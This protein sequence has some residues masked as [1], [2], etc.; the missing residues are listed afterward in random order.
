[1][2]LACE[3]YRVLIRI[4]PADFRRAYGPQMLGIFS[5]TADEKR[6]GGLGALWLFL[7][8]AY[9]DIARTALTER[10]SMI[11]SDLQYALRLASH[12]RASSL[13]MVAT[14]AIAIGVNAAIFSA[15]HAVLL[16]PLPYPNP[17]RLVFIFDRPVNAPNAH[18]SETSLQNEEDWRRL[19]R[20]FTTIGSAAGF[21][22]TRTDITV[23]EALGGYAVTPGVFEALGA[24]PALGR[25]FKQSDMRPGAARSVVISNAYWRSAFGAS[26]D[27]IGKTM[28]LNDE[29]YRI[30]GVLPASF[31]MP[32]RSGFAGFQPDVF[33]SLHLDESTRGAHYLIT[34]ARLKPGVSIAAAQAD[35]D[36]VAALLRARFPAANVQLAE[37]VVPFEDEIFGSPRLMLGVA[38]AAVL[39]ILLVAC[40]NVGNMLL[41]RVAVREPEIA[42]R[43]ALGASR[44]RVITQLFIESALFSVAAVALGLIF[45]AFILNSLTALYLTDLPRIGAIH[46]SVAVL[47]FTAGLI[48]LTTII[49]GVVP[50]LT[51]SHRK[52]GGAMKDTGRGVSESRRKWLHNGA[53]VVELAVALAIV[54]SFGM[55]LRSFVAI[56][57]IEVGFSYDGVVA[58]T[59]VRPPVHRYPDAASRHAFANALL[60]RLQAIP[61]LKNAGLIVSAPLSEGNYVAEEFRIAGVRKDPNAAQSAEY[62]SMTPSALR[63]FGFKLLHGRLFDERD[64][65]QAR[66]VA[67]ITKTFVKQFFPHSNPLGRTIIVG[68]EGSSEPRTIVGVIED[69]KAE[70][71]TETPLPQIVVPIAQ[72]IVPNFQIVGRSSAPA[73]LLDREI[74]SAIRAVDPLMPK[75]QTVRYTSYIADQERPSQSAA[76]LLAFMAIMA[77]LIAAIRTYGVISYT[78]ARRTHEFGVRLALGATR[79]ELMSNVLA[80]TLVLAAAGVAVGFLLAY[81]ASAALVN[82]L[83]QTTSM[84]FTM[85]AAVT[86]VLLATAIAASLEPAIRA[87]RID[88]AAAL[89]YE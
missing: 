50:A 32:T 86:A 85:L 78:V 54:A 77:L 30:I 2:R 57:H 27:A 62:D 72:D 65:M 79:R 35:M 69:Y 49:V 47:L 31:V 88:P 14:L 41:A 63:L 59:P 15:I 68:Y 70:S 8:G 39:A 33:R 46:V 43:F 10:C 82:L 17:E 81:A 1:M 51:L 7:I 73:T 25:L 23:P 4:C 13:L 34:A 71:L 38:L 55:L 42:V 75:R 26:P 53:V 5:R 84:D 18:G 6:R 58:S 28:R 87:T 48:A 52:I 24:K 66:R 80:H 36:R 45:C 61:D 29:T 19:T 9:L 76:Q 37:H 44:R 64:N 12:S 89:H 11:I 3:F 16:A 20:S 60:R 40:L 83:Y 67:L 74:S 22:P 56:S 21:I